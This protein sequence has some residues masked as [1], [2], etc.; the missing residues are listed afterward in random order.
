MSKESEVQ[1]EIIDYL[2]KGG[3]Y[4][5]KTVRSN[6][7]GVPDLIICTLDSGKFYAIEVKAKGKKFNTSKLQKLHLNMINKT[8]GKAFVADSLWDVIEEGL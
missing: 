8:G 5:I 4:V 6:A 7:R 1:K 2:E 3:H